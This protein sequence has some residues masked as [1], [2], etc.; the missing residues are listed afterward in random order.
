MRLCLKC[1]MFCQN[2]GNYLNSKAV[3]IR[4]CWYFEAKLKSSCDFEAKRLTLCSSTSL[5]HITFFHFL[6]QADTLEAH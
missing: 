5:P 6:L 3:V 1:V 2:C 4:K